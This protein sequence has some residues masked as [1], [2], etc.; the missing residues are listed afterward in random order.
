MRV[1]TLADNPVRQTTFPRG[2]GKILELGRRSAGDYRVLPRLVT[3]LARAAC[4]NARGGLCL[5]SPTANPS[6][7]RRVLRVAECPIR[8]AGRGVSTSTVRLKYVHAARTRSLAQSGE[9]K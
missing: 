7:R 1:L 9:L 6:L 4:C 5:F 8:L 3:I 2:L